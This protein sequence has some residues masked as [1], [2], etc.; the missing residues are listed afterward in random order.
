MLSM[1]YET[2]MQVTYI[3]KMKSI[4]VTLLLTTTLSAIDFLEAIV[5][6]ATGLWAIGTKVQQGVYVDAEPKVSFTP[7]VFGSYGFVNIEANRVD[8]T[9]YG[10]GLV[11]ASVVGQYRS[12]EAREETSLYGKRK[13]AFELGGQI[14]LILGAG[15]VLRSSLLYDVSNAHKG[16]EVDTQLFRHDSWGDF[17]LLSSVGVQYQ[18][19]NLTNYYYA[20]QQYAPKPA[21][22]GELELILTYT[23]DH[24]GLFI[25]TRNYFYSSEITKSPIVESAYNL[26]LFSG[27]GYSF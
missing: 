21:F 4:L 24:L 12:Q 18:S 6:P 27:V 11:Y 5:R 23:I 3:Q 15:F 17:S 19:F 26:Q 20:T 2:F 8:A 14:G 22:S 25:G 13:S 1:V 16:Y 10:N 9:L 7:Y